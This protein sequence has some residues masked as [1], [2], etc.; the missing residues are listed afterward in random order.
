MNVYGQRSARR[1][2]TNEESAQDISDYE[3]EAN[4]SRHGL[5][6]KDPLRS[7]FYGD[8]NNMKGAMFPHQHRGAESNDMAGRSPV[9]IRR[10]LSSPTHGTTYAVLSTLV[11]ILPYGHLPHCLLLGH[12]PYEFAYI[13]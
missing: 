6:S 7:S 11:S 8:K 4:N 9:S 12:P 3:S 13:M 5:L 2:D 10:H 1:D